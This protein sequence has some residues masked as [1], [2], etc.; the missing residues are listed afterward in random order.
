MSID[1]VLSMATFLL[2]LGPT[3]PNIYLTNSIY[4]PALCRK[5]ANPWLKSSAFKSMPSAMWW[6]SPILKTLNDS[7]NALGAVCFVLVYCQNPKSRINMS[8]ISPA[9]SLNTHILVY[10][11]LSE[12]TLHIPPF[13]PLLNV[14]LL[15]EIYILLQCLASVN[16]LGNACKHQW[17]SSLNMNTVGNSWLLQRK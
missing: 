7:S 16:Y 1:Y 15:T 14:Y 17:Y 2:Q 5:I 6:T 12:N 9:T 11:L 4:Y 8:N 10:Q 13:F 3:K